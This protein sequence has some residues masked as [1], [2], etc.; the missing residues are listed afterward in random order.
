MTEPP[1]LKILKQLPAPC[2][3]RGHPVLDKGSKILIL[4]VT[5]HPN[6][7]PKPSQMPTQTINTVPKTVLD[8]PI[9]PPS[10]APTPTQQNGIER[11]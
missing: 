9:T 4:T 2:L 1:I 5:N 8:A 3:T 11:N 10:S 6:T 7:A